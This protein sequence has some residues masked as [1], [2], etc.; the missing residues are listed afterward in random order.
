MIL[1]GIE[2]FKFSVLTKEWKVKNPYLS[3]ASSEEEKIEYDFQKTLFLISRMVEE[4]YIEYV[5][6][7]IKHCYNNLVRDRLRVEFNKMKYCQ[8]NNQCNLF[9]PYYSNKCSIS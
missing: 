2:A 5:D 1:T 9:C 3:K 8:G 7:E 4:G 6:K